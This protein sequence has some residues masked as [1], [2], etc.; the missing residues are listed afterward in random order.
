MLLA[1][2]VLGFRV[3]ANGQGEH[4]GDVGRGL[5][6]LEQGVEKGRELATGPGYARST[7]RR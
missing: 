7:F 4:Q 6:G 3:F 1:V 2:G 5:D